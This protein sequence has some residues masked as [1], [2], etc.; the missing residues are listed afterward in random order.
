MKNTVLAI[1]SSASIAIVLGVVMMNSQNAP[2][3]AEHDDCVLILRKKSF[4][5][6]VDLVG[7]RLDFTKAEHP[8][9]IGVAKWDS[10]SDVPE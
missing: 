2:A 1:L 5:Y 3:A 4:L 9:I 10:M 6:N 7:V 8:T